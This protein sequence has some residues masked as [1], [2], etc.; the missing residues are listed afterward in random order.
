MAE[1]SA[2][3]RW[4]L[5]GDRR[6]G[7]MA[8]ALAVG[9]DRAAIEPRLSEG[10]VGQLEADLTSLREAGAGVLGDLGGQ[11]AAT[12]AERRTAGEGHELIMLV[13][14]AGRRRAGGDLELLAAL[15]VGDRLNP[16]S[17][18]GVL[19]GLESIVRLGGEDGDGLRRIGVLPSDI[20][21]AGAIA[22]RLRGADATQWERITSRSAGTEGR[23]SLR[24]RVEAAVD[25]IAS[26]GALAFRRD[27]VKLA[28]YQA[29]VADVAVEADE[30]EA[31]PEE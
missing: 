11:K 27:P 18:Q 3:P 14:E 6:R 2:N 1:T 21:E 31:P 13:R 28:R 20:E 30:A 25:E 10:L 24:L 9:D 7:E 26:A 23:T 17:T 5:A 15:G 29:M 19:A 12:G 22:G 8:Y 16:R 4:T